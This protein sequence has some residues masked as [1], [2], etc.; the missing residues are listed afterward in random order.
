[1]EI[2]RLLCI[3][4]HILLLK[5]IRGLQFWADTFRFSPNNCSGYD[6]EENAFKVT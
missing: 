5:N 2:E 1:M 4:H 3:F 6:E